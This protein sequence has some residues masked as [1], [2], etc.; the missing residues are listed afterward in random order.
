VLH[1]LPITRTERKS[2]QSCLMHTWQAYCKG[3][4]H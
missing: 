2:V 4:L 3:A 1:A